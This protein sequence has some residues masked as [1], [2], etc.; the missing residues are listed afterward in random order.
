MA[1]SLIRRRRGHSTNERDWK[2]SKNKKIYKIKNKRLTGRTSEQIIVCCRFRFTAS[3]FVLLQK[4]F[5]IR[6]ETKP[7][8]LTIRTSFGI[9]LSATRREI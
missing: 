4:L 2:D 6:N 5:S 3:L 1:K 7:K 9:G 8:I